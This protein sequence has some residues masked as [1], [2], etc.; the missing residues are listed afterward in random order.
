MVSFMCE[1]LFTKRETYR[2]SEWGIGGNRKRLAGKRVQTLIY[3]IN[4]F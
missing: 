4:K 3:K 1:I 2:N